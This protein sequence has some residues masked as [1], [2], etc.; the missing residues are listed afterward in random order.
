MVKNILQSPLLP[1]VKHTYGCN[2][3]WL[4]AFASK[5]S[6]RAIMPLSSC[7]VIIRHYLW[8][9]ISSLLAASAFS[10]SSERAFAPLTQSSNACFSKKISLP[11]GL[12]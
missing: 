8:F 4:T 3:D 6:R 5:G 7:S 11:A 12:K 10:S 1:A 9:N 2:G